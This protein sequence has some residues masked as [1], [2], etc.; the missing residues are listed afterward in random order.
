MHREQ[1]QCAD[2]SGALVLPWNRS[3]GGLY[4]ARRDP[5]DCIEWL[6]ANRKRE[7]MRLNKPLPHLRSE[8][9]Y[10]PKWQLG[11]RKEIKPRCVRVPS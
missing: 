9:I 1:C 10:W 5:S 6:H 3:T 8:G 11:R 2:V 7:R 4:A